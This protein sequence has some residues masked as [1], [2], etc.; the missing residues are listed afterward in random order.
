MMS[1]PT[2]GKYGPDFWKI[3]VRLINNEYNLKLNFTASQFTASLY[4]SGKRKMFV[5]ILTHTWSHSAGST[6]LVS[7]VGCK[8]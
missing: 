6:I 1:L 2:I 8:S 7:I 5:N 4:E 3:I